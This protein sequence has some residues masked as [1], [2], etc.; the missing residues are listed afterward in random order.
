MREGV[1]RAAAMMRMFIHIL[2]IEMI[3]IEERVTRAKILIM[4][5]VTRA[6]YAMAID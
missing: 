2:I 3:I 6:A 4:H 5:S 1:L